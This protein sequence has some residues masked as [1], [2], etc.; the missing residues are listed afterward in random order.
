LRTTDKPIGIIAE[1]LGF[2]N[3]SSFSTVFRRLT[4]ESPRDFRS[5]QI[6]CGWASQS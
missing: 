6:I 5:R 3:A 2:A 1:E 4:G